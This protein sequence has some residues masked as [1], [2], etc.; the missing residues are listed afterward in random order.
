MFPVRKPHRRFTSESPQ[1]YIINQRKSGVWIEVGEGEGVWVQ[2]EEE[3]ELE[4]RGRDTG[5]RRGNGR[6]KDRFGVSPS[7]TSSAKKAYCIFIDEWNFLKHTNDIV[8]Q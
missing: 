4:V 8:C 5:K 7:K 6:S 1:I 2:V 3:V